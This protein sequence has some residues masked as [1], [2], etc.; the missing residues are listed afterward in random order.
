MQ[1]L[2]NIYQTYFGSFA[3]GE[4]EFFNET[5][6]NKT[7]LPIWPKYGDEKKYLNFGFPKNQASIESHL[8]EEECLFWNSI[9]KSDSYS[10]YPW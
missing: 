7:H 10:I 3:R 9:R 1:G 6:V 5:F 4:F 2:S 8:M